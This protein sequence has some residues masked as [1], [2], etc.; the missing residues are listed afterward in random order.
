MDSRGCAGD[1]FQQLMLVVAGEGRNRQTS[2]LPPYLLA[3]VLSEL[4]ALV[5]RDI[6]RSA[7][8]PNRRLA[9]LQLDPPHESGVG[10]T[11]VLMTQ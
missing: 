2:L 4:T 7:N 5:W 3:T 11:S 9:M 6:P 8:L 10:C 1:E